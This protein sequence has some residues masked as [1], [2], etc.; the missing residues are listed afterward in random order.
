MGFAQSVGSPP[1]RWVLDT[2]TTMALA[3]QPA[4]LSEVVIIGSDGTIVARANASTTDHATLTGWLQ[5]AAT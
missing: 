1:F 4:T 5:Q 2:N 3:F